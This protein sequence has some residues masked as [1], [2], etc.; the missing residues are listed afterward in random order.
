[1]SVP[2]PF[3]S[4]PVPPEIV[5][6][7]VPEVITC[8]FPES[9]ATVNDVAILAIVLFTFEIALSVYVVAFE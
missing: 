7:S 9:A 2:P 3:V 4:I 5:K 8:E 6:V 1:M